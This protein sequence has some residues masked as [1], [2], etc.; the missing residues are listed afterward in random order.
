ALRSFWVVAITLPQYLASNAI[1]LARPGAQG[2]PRDLV[3][4]L[5]DY[6]LSWLLPLVVIY[7]LVLWYGRAER[8]WL[9]LSALN[10]SQV[11]QALASLAMTALFLGAGI[12]VDPE[13]AQAAMTVPAA[14]GHLMALV[15]MLLFVGLILYEW[16]VAWVALEAGVALPIAAVLLDIVIGYGVGYGIDHLMLLL[17]TGHWA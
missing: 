8:Y 1:P 11:P 9:L 14:I 16:Y 10:W 6:A 2:L 3:A 17:K 5:A 4:N 7:A 15:G 13:A 12:L